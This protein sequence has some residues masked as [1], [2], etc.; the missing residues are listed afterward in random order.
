MK[1]MTGREFEKI[2]S[3]QKDKLPIAIRHKEFDLR[4]KFVGCW[5]ESLVIEING[6]YALW[7]CELCESEKPDYP[8]PSYS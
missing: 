4:G 8:I 3:L 7:P 6:Q 2:C 5:E 1:A